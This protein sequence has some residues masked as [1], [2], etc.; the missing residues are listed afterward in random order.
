M[1]VTVRLVVLWCKMIETD[2]STTDDQRL[3]QGFGYTSSIDVEAA[4]LASSSDR[5]TSVL[6]SYICMHDE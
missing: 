6:A 4:S 5:S 2:M 3:E 1:C